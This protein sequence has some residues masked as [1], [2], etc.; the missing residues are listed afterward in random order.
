MP[1]PEVIRVP[2]ETYNYTAAYREHGNM[3]YL[4]EGETFDNVVA[5]DGAILAEH[6]VTAEEVG[7]SLRHMFSTVNTYLTVRAPRIE[8]PL[9]GVVLTMQSFMGSEF[10]PYIKGL[11]SYRDWRVHTANMSNGNKAYHP[12]AGATFVSDMLPEMIAELGF[13]EGAVFY[14]IQPL[15]AIEIHRMIE[16]YQPPV[17]EPVHTVDAW[18]APTPWHRFKERV[19]ADICDN[20]WAGDTF[21]PGVTALWAPGSIA[22]HGWDRYTGE[23]QFAYRYARTDTDHNR[24]AEGWAVLYAEE[25]TPIPPYVELFGKPI[26][27]HGTEL[28]AGTNVVRYFPYNEKHVA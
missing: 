9:P 2:P 22:P 4:A 15:W 1:T 10:S 7:Q 18:D 24:K 13:F 14:G 11:S 28:K 20:A 21:L 16:R 17:Y 6:G 27:K 19:V 23:P 8:S 25:D 3:R 5:H 26:D 12:I